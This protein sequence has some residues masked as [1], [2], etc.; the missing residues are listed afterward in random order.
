MR[1]IG[2]FILLVMLFTPATQAAEPDVIY[3]P[4]PLSKNDTRF[5]YHLSLLREA[6]ERTTPEYGPFEMKT[7]GIK[8]NQLR[9]IDL[10]QT[11]HPLLDVIIKPTSIERERILMPVRIPLEKG[12]LG[13]RIMLIRRADQD[14]LARTQGLDD[15]K[16]YTIGQGLGWG[17]VK[18][19][20]HNGLTV[21]EGNAYEGLF[22][23]LLSNRFD[24]FPRGMGEAFDEWDTRHEALPGLHVEETILLHYPFAR[25]FWTARTAR[26]MRLN[27]RIT[28]GLESMIQDGFFDALF[29][30]HYGEIIRRGRLRNRT[31]INLQ[32]PDLPPAT[33]LGRKELWFDPFDQ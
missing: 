28:K 22:K 15:L 8:M 17:D 11:G 20:R 16:Q 7:A 3:Y 18:I 19:L 27:Q 21:L 26:G 1:T 13:W 4:R 10:L 5:D 9:Q 33:P 6:L 23:M 14:A 32:N 2:L 30:A 24:L 12:L 31:L 29:N 25:Y